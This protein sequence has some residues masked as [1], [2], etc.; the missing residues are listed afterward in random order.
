MHA[1][2]L[3][4]GALGIFHSLVR[5]GYSFAPYDISTYFILYECEGHAVAITSNLDIT[6]AELGEGNLHMV[7]ELVVGQCL[8]QAIRC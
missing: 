4:D 1:A 3:G 6:C 8:R 5:L 7:F 2:A